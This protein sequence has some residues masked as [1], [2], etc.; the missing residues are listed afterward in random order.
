[1]ESIGSPALS[2]KMM[3][4]FGK[5]LK[6]HLIICMSFSKNQRILPLDDKTFMVFVAHL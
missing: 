1:M 3:K 5:L 2:T 6:I 4:G